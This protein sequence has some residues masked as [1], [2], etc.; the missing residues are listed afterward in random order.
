MPQLNP[1]PISVINASTVLSDS[2]IRPVVDALQQQVS[3]DF[4]PA[5]GVDAKL[6]FCLWADTLAYL[7]E[8]A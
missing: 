3:R 4:L 6:T 2:D 5:W 8:P 1:I 7:M